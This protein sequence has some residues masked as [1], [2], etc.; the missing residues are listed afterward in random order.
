M[1]SLGLKIVGSQT[2][3]GRQGSLCPLG[4]YSKRDLSDAFVIV[5]LALC[6]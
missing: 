5:A 3:I 4:S 2:N 1:L 6:I